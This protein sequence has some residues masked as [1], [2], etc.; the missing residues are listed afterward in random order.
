MSSR[1]R[2]GSSQ[3]RPANKSRAKAQRAQGR[4]LFLALFVC[5][6]ACMATIALNWNDTPPDACRG[7]ALTIGNFDGVHGG[8]QAL[9]AE[10][11]RQAAALSG[12]AVVLTFDPHPL[13]LLR[14]ER[15][16]PLLTTPA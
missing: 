16:Q 9:L 13:Q 3:T 6:H 2:S 8:H 12:P 15:F 5:Y 14:P 11:R 7:G 1:C 10:L 4:W